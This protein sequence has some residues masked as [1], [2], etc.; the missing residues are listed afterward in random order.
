MT[1]MVHDAR[2][3][4]LN[5]RPQLD[6]GI[7]L[8]AGDSR[9]YWEGDTLVVETKNFNGLTQSFPPS[10]YGTSYDKFLSERFTRVGRYTT[11]YEFTIEDPSTFT[12]KITAIVPISKVD[13][14][15][16]EYACHAG[17]YGMANMLRG[18][19]QEERMA[20]AA[21]GTE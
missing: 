9:G 7:L 4:P 19:R 2:I 21:E 12:D 10:A 3:V 14:L 18:A 13:G 11:G 17:N 1:E 16:Y 8:W 6:D 15:L 5:H 20:A